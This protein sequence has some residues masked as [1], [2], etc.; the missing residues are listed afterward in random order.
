MKIQYISNGSERWSSSSD[1]TYSNLGNP[2]SLDLYDVNI[3]SLQSELLWRYDKDS[4]KCL[5]CTNDFSSIKEMVKT[6]STAINIILLPQN[7]SHLYRKTSSGSYYYSINL[8][9]EIP[10]LIGNLL[11]DII[12]SPIANQFELIY[13]NSITQF[14][15]SEFH[16]SFCFSTILGEADVV[17][18]ALGSNKITTIR[19]EKMILS[20]LHLKSKNTDFD[21]FINGMGL[22]QDRLETPDWLVALDFFDDSTQKSSIA[23]NEARIVELNEQIELSKQKIKENLKYKSILV[24][25][26]DE[27]VKVVF[28]MLEK[29]F[30]YDLSKFIDEKREDFIIEKD[31]FSFVGEIKGVNSNVKYGNV[32]QTETHCKNYMDVLESE[33]RKSTVK[34]ILIINT[35]RKTPLDKR[36]P[37]NQVQIDLAKKYDILIITTETFLKLYE[38][39]IDG[40]VNGELIENILKTKTGLLGVSD[41][42]SSSSGMVDNSAYTI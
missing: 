39:L 23:E 24:T 37:V 12:P 16:S 34:G 7:F 8:K 13:E 20:T 5:N 26:G 11:H 40:D 30:S 28:E 29:I 10:N 3:F 41:F 9:D 31:G 38:M 4:D 18:R 15:G 36:E 6:S 32:S 19:R 2:F 35:F 21:D 27:L 25:S 22:V 1:I 14:C 42:I 33:N 17:S